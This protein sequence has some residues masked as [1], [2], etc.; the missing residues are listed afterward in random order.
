MALKSRRVERLR[1]AA[2]SSSSDDGEGMH[3]GDDAQINAETGM[4]LDFPDTDADPEGVGLLIGDDDDMGA[5]SRMLYS[6]R[7]PHISLSFQLSGPVWAASLLFR[8]V[9][10]GFEVFK[11]PGSLNLHSFAVQFDCKLSDFLPPPSCNRF[12]S[13][14]LSSIG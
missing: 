10:D 6:F 8:T 5:S 3:N 4:A 14:C 11:E 1:G 7:L 9:P 2:E 13:P 12:F